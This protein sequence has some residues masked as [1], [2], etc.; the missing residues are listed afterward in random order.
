MKNLAK[1]VEKLEEETPLRIKNKN[2]KNEP[3]GTEI[4]AKGHSHKRSKAFKRKKHTDR[5]RPT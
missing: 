1:V 4:V 3:N 5:I 2:R